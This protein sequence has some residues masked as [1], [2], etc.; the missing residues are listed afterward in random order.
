MSSLRAPGVLVFL[1]LAVVGCDE[2]G[3]TPDDFQYFVYQVDYSCQN[4]PPGG[5]IWRRR[6]EAPATLVELKDGEERRMEVSASKVRAFAELVTRDDVLSELRSKT[7]CSAEPPQDGRT[8]MELGLR[9][10]PSLRRYLNG[11]GGEPYVSIENSVARLPLM[12]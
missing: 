9:G 4:A 8:S 7:T 3:A 2:V 6:I 10:Q 5:C 11:C 1:A 12:E